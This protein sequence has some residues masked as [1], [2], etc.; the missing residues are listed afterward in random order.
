[1]DEIVVISSFEFANGKILHPQNV[2]TIAVYN[3]AE[4]RHV[5][6]VNH[7]YRKLE[8]NGESIPFLVEEDLSDEQAYELLEKFT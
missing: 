7:K 3:A 4:K 8:I 1:M 6:D 2:Y 5:R